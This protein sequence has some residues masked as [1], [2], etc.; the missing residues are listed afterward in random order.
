M[1]NRIFVAGEVCA[2]PEQ[3]FE[4]SSCTFLLRCQ[5]TGWD[6]RTSEATVPVRVSGERK[7]EVVAT[8]IKQGT[9]LVVRGHLQDGA[10]GVE[11]V[12]EDWQF[13]NK[14]VDGRCLFLEHQAA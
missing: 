3:D 6:G 4:T 12:S 13:L 10:D 1:I 2:D 9:K 11:L 7:A 8:W 5:H 14:N